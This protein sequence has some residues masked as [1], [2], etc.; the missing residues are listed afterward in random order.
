M[1]CSDRIMSP[2]YL[3]VPAGL[4]PAYSLCQNLCIGIT[5]LSTVLTRSV[6]QGQGLHIREQFVC[7]DNSVVRG[8]GI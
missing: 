4:L 8:G 3:T 6:I 1:R 5:G 2:L 7:V